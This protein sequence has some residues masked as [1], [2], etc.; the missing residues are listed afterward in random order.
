VPHRTWKRRPA[1]P[2]LLIIGA[3]KA[4]TTSLH[5]YL[6]LHPQ[7]F[8]SRRKE[9][10]FFDDHIRWNLGIDW[11]K[12]N[13]DARYEINGEASPQYS[14][15]P[16][17]SGVPERI[18]RILGIPK[19]IYMI[20]DPIDRILSNYIEAVDGGHTGG[21]R[22]DDIAAH[23]EGSPEQFIQ[24]SCYF[25]Q[26]SN[27]LEHFR[28]EHILVVPLE[29]MRSDLRGTLRGI[30][31]F[32]GVD[33]EFWSPEFLRRLNV[34]CNKRFE[35]RWFKQFAPTGVRRQ[36]WRPTW[37][38]WPI[39]RAIHRVARIGGAPIVKPNLTLEDD[40]RLQRILGPD[41]A[42]LRQFLADPLPEW[43]PY[44]AD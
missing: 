40:A 19:I 14:R 22:F 28:K 35:A 18:S 32:L 30:F 10:N 11:Y 39:N 9:L 13:F 44:M 4:G 42:S 6:S 17:V 34:A 25:L 38:P 3:A 16:R 20:R 31:Q 37:M 29:R 26:I 27:Y 7:I 15:Y 23:I 43:R 8:M 1:L 2:N 24:A 12:S 36:L 5:N 33:A 21:A 41:V